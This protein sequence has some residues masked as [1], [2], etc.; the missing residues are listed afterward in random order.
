MQNLFDSCPH[1]TEVIKSW[2]NEK[3][4]ESMEETREYPEE[5][6]E[7]MRTQSVANEQLEELININPRFV[8]DVFD[9]NSVYINVLY[10]GSSFTWNIT[11]VGEMRELS[12]PFKE[13]NGE[14]SSRK[15]AE[16]DALSSAFFILN[17]Y[18]KTSLVEE[19]GSNNA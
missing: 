9:D 13:T 12:V 15:E 5:F 19:N 10:T 2:L 16:F 3:M 14:F 1:T 18:L 11:L 4:L 6:K 7:F 17:E 8:Y